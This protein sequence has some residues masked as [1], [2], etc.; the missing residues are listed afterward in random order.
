MSASTASEAVVKAAPRIVY[1][2]RE[3]LAFSRD[4]I[5]LKRPKNMLA[6]C[7]RSLFAALAPLD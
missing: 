3:L 1:S 6:D 7:E 5:C 2:K 4:K